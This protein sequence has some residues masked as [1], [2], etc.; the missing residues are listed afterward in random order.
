MIMSSATSHFTN[1]FHLFR[2][3]KGSRDVE[4]EDFDAKSD[5]FN[6]SSSID[7]LIDAHT[8]EESEKISFV[9]GDVVLVVGGE[10]KS[11]TGKVISVDE[12][13]RLVKIAPMHSDMNHEVSVEANLLIK[14]I[15]PGAHVKVRSDLSSQFISVFFLYC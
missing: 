15:K 5:I 7:T 6:F 11:L 1:L 3:V 8:L 14:Q 4:Y 10:L 2:E 13:S 9:A 12:T